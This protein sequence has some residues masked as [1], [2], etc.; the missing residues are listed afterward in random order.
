MSRLK[1]HYSEN[2]PC[3]ITILLITLVFKTS[4]KVLEVFQFKTR[5]RF[6]TMHRLQLASEQA[7]FSERSYPSM[8]DIF[9]YAF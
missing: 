9:Y 6:A 5:P 2:V 8:Y 3:F 1:E 4:L 7:D